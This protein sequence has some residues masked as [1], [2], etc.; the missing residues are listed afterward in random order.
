MIGEG[1]FSHD[2]NA[3][4]RVSLCKMSLRQKYGLEKNLHLELVL[5]LSEL[6]LRLDHSVDA[7]PEVCH[8]LLPERHDR[9]DGGGRKV[10]LVEPL[11]DV[12][13]KRVHLEEINVELRC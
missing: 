6:L 8:D 12:S 3:L 11:E 10:G 2:N 7:V 1:T 13:L 4:Y 5:A 9:A